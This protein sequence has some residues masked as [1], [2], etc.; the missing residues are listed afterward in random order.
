MPGLGIGVASSFRG[1]RRTRRASAP[2][3]AAVLPASAPLIVGQRLRDTENWAIFTTAANYATSTDGADI[4]SVTVAYIGDAPDADTPFTDGQTNSF[5]I[6]VTDTAGA[7]RVFAVVPRQV[8]HAPPRLDGV[9]TDLSFTLGT[10]LQRYDISGLFTG[11]DLTFS[12]ISLPGVSID[13]TTGIIDFDTDLLPLVPD[14]SAVVTAINSGGSAAG[15]FAFELRPPLVLAA[16]ITG[17]SSSATY[18]EYAQ[19]GTAL[20]GVVTG[21]LGDESLIHR[22]QD[23]GGVIEGADGASYIPLADQDFEALRYVPLVNGD[24]VTSPAYT[25]RHAPPIAG[26]LAPVSEILGSGTPT[27]NLTAGFTG[28]A[29]SFSEFVPWAQIDGTILTIDDALRNDIVTITATNS[30]GQASVDLSVTISAQP[31]TVPAQMDPPG[32][33]ATSPNEVT[34]TLAADPDDGGAPITARGIRYSPDGTTWLFAGGIDSPHVLSG[35][36][37]ETEYFVQA[38]VSNA[39]GVGPWSPSVSVTTLATPP[40]PAPTFNAVRTGSD[41]T[42]SNVPDVAAQSFT[43]TQDGANLIVTFTDPLQTPVP[44]QL[45]ILAAEN[46]DGSGPETGRYALEVLDLGTPVDNVYTVPV[47][48][49]PPGAMVVLLAPDADV[50]GGGL[51]EFKRVVFVGASILAQ[52]FGTGSLQRVPE[53]EALFLDRGAAIEVYVHAVSG[54]DASAIQTLLSE[55]MAAFPQDTLFFVHAGGN[56][57]TDARPYPGGAA[58]LTAALEGLADIAATRP[59]SVILSDLTFRD[60][61]GTTVQDE[62]A[63][64]RPYNDT[65]YRPLFQTRKADL[66]DRA[67]YDDG[68]PVSCLYEWSHANRAAYLSADTIHPANPEGRVLLRDWLVDRLTPLCLGQP[69]PAQEDRVTLAPMTESVDLFVQYGTNTAPGVNT[70]GFSLATQNAGEISEGPFGLL[71]ADG[72]NPGV[73]LRLDFSAPAPG[74]ASGF[75][76]NFQGKTVPVASFDG[77]LYNGTFTTDS[78]FVGAAYTVDH[79]LSGLS[80]D[81]D[82]RVGLVASRDAGGPRETLYSFSNGETATIET[83]ADPVSLPV[84]VDTRSDATGTITITQS[85]NSGAWSYLGG[86]HIS[87]I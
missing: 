79:V 3:T 28:E 42:L 32:V 23:S 57:V 63:G 13:S 10:G 83:T 22:W 1:R 5:S 48:T 41:L 31:V 86:L 11:A 78:Y 66:L 62:A 54:S 47:T 29:L 34:V 44:R 7:E 43:A 19:I 72:S 26:T 50:V 87:D 82:Y 35:L 70:P 84:F 21:L 71:N 14:A 6:T 16:E 24:A 76:L 12:I 67:Y 64:T 46:H 37:A 69:A 8:V 40:L 55:A 68:T 65:V 73:T 53:A 45:G 9:L 58:T 74:N 52:T 38:R 20:T 77:S 85:A 15:T 60:Y 36:V 25:V 33:V 4:A 18:G 17:L 56:D 80:P 51:S 30:G 49:V 59:G 27:V 39:V 75:G 2:I 61:D 81:T